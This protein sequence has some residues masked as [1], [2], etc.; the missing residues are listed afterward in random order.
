MRFR[1]L[2]PLLI[3]ALLLLWPRLGVHATTSYA[4][5][6]WNKK[7]A[8]YLEIP[9]ASKVGSDTCTGC[10]DATS[11]NFEHAFHKQQGVE[12]EDCHGDGSLHV[13]G[14]GDVAK[15]VS[16][17]KRPVE[18]ANGVCLGCHSRDEKVRY[19][20]GA[21]HAV[22]HVRCVDCHRVHSRALKAASEKRMN[23]DTATSGATQA[24]F[25]SPE[26]DVILQPRPEM[27]DSCLKCHPTQNGQL[28]MPYHHPLREGKMTCMDCH[29]P[30]GGPAG[31][32]LRTANMNQLCLSCHAQYRGPFA[33][34]HPP[35]TENCMLCH[36]AHGSPNT[37]LLNVSEPALCLQCHSGHHNGAGLPLPDR[38]TNCHGSIHGTDTPT[39]SGGSRFVDKGPSDPNLIAAANSGTALAAAHSTVSGSWIPNP[40]A[41]HAPNYALS[42]AAGAAGMMSGMAP[43][44][45]GN[46][47]DGNNDPTV[48]EVGA[49]AGAYSITP[50]AYRFLDGTGYLGRV[51]EYD[52]LEQSAGANAVTAYVSPQNHLT[53]V[54]R[55]TV[56]TGDDYY[57]K[58]QLTAGQWLK[59]GF[60]M[61]SFVQ[62]QDNYPFYAFPVLDVP[63]PGVAP[64]DTTTDLI[65]SHTV[66]GVTR[67]LGNAYARVKVPKIPVH[68]F[69][70]GNWQ[71]RSGLTQF[72]YLDENT[73]LA[74]S[75]YVPNSGMVNPT[76]GQQCHWNSQLQRINYTTRNI[77]GGADVDL[78]PVR[79]TYEHHFSSFNDRLVFPTG[80]FT[81]PFTPAN[82]GISIVNPPPSGPAP[83]DVAAGNYPINIT[84]PSQVQTDAVNL[85]WTAS[86]KLTFN[87]HVSYARLLD[88][89][90]N[91][92]QNDF[93][94][95]AI[96]NWRPLDRL[97]VT[98]DYHQQNLINNFTPY[99]SLY[100]NVS[101]HNHWEGLRLNYQLSKGFDVEGSYR[102]SGI[103]RS[104]AFLWP[105]V[106]SIDNTDLLTVVPSSF[107]NTFGMALRYHD[108]GNWSAR[109]GDEWTG[110]HD[111]GY[112][113]IPQS[114]NRTFADI[115]LTPRNWLVL[116]SDTNII[117]Q[118]DFTAVPLP[119]T[120]G[121]SPGIG[122]DIAG[123]PPNFQRRDRFYYETLSA[124]FRP[125]PA[126]NL[127]L[128]YSY[129]QNDL[130]TYMAFQNDSSVGYVLEE[131]LVP[132]KQI[133][134]AWWG[135][136]SYTFKRR[137]GVNLRLTYNSS[138]SGMRP[139]VNP[140]DAALLG[141]AALI[142]QGTFNQ[143]AFGTPGQPLCPSTALCNA[144][145]AA[146]QISQV[147]VP[148][149]I[150]LSKAY[151]LFP[152]KVE[153]GLIF[154]YGS[155]RD[156]WNPNLNGILRTF[157]LYV[158]KS[159]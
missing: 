98:A 142:S 146:T 48:S 23:F 73:T 42:A 40:V 122:A 158:G 92:P 97:R 91:N 43:L 133:T 93:D 105:Q 143:S 144:E 135:D 52:S 49:V 77:G 110:T 62:Q 27:N 107:S 3:V 6:E 59:A 128:G 154:Y 54:S 156:Y 65:P 103:T 95:D 75:S 106:Y 34:Q 28:S 104:N 9:G 12:C 41:S 74:P 21:S 67:R 70:N 5:G 89:F 44:S 61:R 39:P 101:Y 157:N 83:V 55:A 113:I 94:S 109:V 99:Y 121:E 108:R 50:G 139:N 82:E 80:T 38:C 141:N 147:I 85:N 120:P 8:R 137:M 124:T 76:C 78:G 60:D 11:K 129:Q 115:W 63:S 151:Y 64:P 32:N 145:F 100:G 13:E 31:N 47:W 149:W 24:N 87:G 10:H 17:S 96:L 116:S 114:N 58:A 132:Y 33:Y 56:L 148:Q 159:W 102:R 134:N 81:G 84:A 46:M 35:V 136:S 131:P 22:N 30:H 127:G 1:L 153:G 118:N 53:I 111:P 152:Y 72:A 51:G 69:V 19:W 26:T 45:G 117:V 123:L 125:R 4:P 20:I 36:T 140:A 18:T 119:N 112:L 14:G 57:G 86:P 71:A 138:R 2:S 79:L 16:F 90:T 88:T 66:F 130:N 25:V 68:L 15:I 37:N 29:D 155:Y 150:G 126:W 7:F